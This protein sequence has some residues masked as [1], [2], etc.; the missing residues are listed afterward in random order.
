MQPFEEARV[1]VMCG[2]SGSGKT[3]LARRLAA[4]YGFRIISA[5]D[6]LWQ[7]CGD[8]F[9]SI[10]FAEQRPY[11]E[12]AAAMVDDALAEA[13]AHG[14][15]VVVD[16]TMCRRSRRDAVRTLCRSHGVE[17]LLVYLDPPLEV[18]KKRMEHR[19]G[20][21]PHDQTVPAG[22]LEMFY[23]NF[24]RPTPDEDFIKC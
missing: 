15:R 23:R 9:P 5:D 4:D 10:P 21:G 20:L 22:R 3:F 18:L 24:D 14:E 6:M 17:P 7:M 11:F 19:N 13:L 1:I 8:T 16:S 12:K 2:V